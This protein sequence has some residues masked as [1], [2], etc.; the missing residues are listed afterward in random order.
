MTTQNPLTSG[1]DG[2]IEEGD[3][4]KRLS[5][6]R[7]VTPRR[8]HTGLALAFL[9]TAFGGFAPSYSAKL[10]HGDPSAILHVHALFFT[11]WLV[12]LVAQAALVRSRRVGLHKRLGIAGAVLAA[13]MLPTGV[14]VALEAAQLRGGTPSALKL[15]SVQFGALLLFAGFVAIAV[16]KRRRSEV[17]RRMIVLATVSIIPAAIVRLPLIGGNPLFALVLST[18]FVVAGIVHDCF[19]GRPHPVYVWGGLVIVLSGPARVLFGQTSAWQAIA[20]YLL[21]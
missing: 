1:I 8:F 6:P 15:L 9:L 19:R 18:L 11:G 4:F 21:G 13:A 12:L 17:H 7:S 3:A 5:T 2:L 16:W 14:L 10:S 20:G